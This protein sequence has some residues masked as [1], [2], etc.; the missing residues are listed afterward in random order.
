[1]LSPYL[2]QEI[3]SIVIT[4][5]PFPYCVALL[6][7]IFNHIYSYLRCHGLINEHQSAVTQ[8]D[9]TFNQLIAICNKLY[10]NIDCG[11]KMLVVYFDLTKVFDKVWHKILLYKIKK[12]EF[13]R[14]LHK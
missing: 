7:L 1:M 14:N 4:I 10:K 8:G 5:A 9:S 6:K 13:K 3:L 2:R 12:C 11:N